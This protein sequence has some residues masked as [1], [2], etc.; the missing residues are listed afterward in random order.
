MASKATTAKVALIT[1]GSRGIGLGIA[2]RLADEGYRL[3][4]NGVRSEDEVADVL[5]EL[6]Q[7]SDEVVYCQGDVSSASDRRR[8][9]ETVE[10]ALGQLNVLVNNVGVAPLQRS[11]ILEEDEA[12]YDRV[13]NINLKGPYFLT[14]AAANWM[15][16]QR[17]ENADMSACIVNISSISAHVVSVHRGGYCLTKA[18]ITMATQLWAVRLAEFGIPVYEVCPGVIE[19]D[20]TAGVRE[21]YEKLI[22]EGL[23]LEPRI[24]EPDDVGRAVAMLARGD[25]SYAT[26]QVLNVDGGLMI[27]RL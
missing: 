12:S 1:G 6:R 18:A 8:I 13:M 20:M 5:G 14:Q 11:D 22:A 9:V 23:T 24:G 25:L 27:Q 4:I 19:T 16:R 15:I 21:K 17:R 26:G 7:Q 10:Q 2:R 3:A